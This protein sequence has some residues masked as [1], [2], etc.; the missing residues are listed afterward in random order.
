MYSL[1]VFATVEYVVKLKENLRYVDVEVCFSGADNETRPR[2]LLIDRDTPRFISKVKWNGSER[3]LRGT[4]L[5]VPGDVRTGCLEYR[6]RL[7]SG[8]SRWGGSSSDFVLTGSK[9]WLLAP[10]EGTDAIIRFETPLN[11][12]VS[13]PWP[14]ATATEIPSDYE[15]FQLAQ[16]PASWSNNIAFGR[17]E[18][19]QIPVANTFLR[20][21]VLPSQPK[22]PIKLARAWVIESAEAALASH[23]AL[24]QRE[25][26]V[27]ITPVG[28][29]NEAIPFARVMRGGGIGLQ[30]FVDQS[31]VQQKYS[32]DWKPTHEF[33]HLLLPYISRKDAWLSEGLASY[34]QNVLRARDGRLT[35][36]QAWDKLLAGFERGRRGTISKRTL[37]E[38]ASGMHRNRSYHRVYWSGAAMLMLADVRL[39]IE[40]GGQKSLDSA[41]AGLVDCCMQLGK[42]W[43]GLEMMQQ[44]DKVSG[45]SV[46]TDVYHRY[47][48]SRDFPK[49]EDTL[50]RLGVVERR[51]SIFFDEQAPQDKIRR[52]IMSK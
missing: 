49:V 42:V 29:Q 50:R 20:M 48:R 11:Y 26:Q 25:P 47:T 18:I 45:V 9:Q 15:W 46:F 35:Q 30:F 24:P 7:E 6:A 31:Q 16:T 38:E 36:N 22:M 52:A 27:L 40:S 12:S 21:V 41:L 33:A 34:Y 43:T 28:T 19:H 8:G 4:R 37:S 51:G 2:N 14:I 23:G 13:H 32:D 1:S 3:R 5:G 44:L 39:R 10:Q 17:F